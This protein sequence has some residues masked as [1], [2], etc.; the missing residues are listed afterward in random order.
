MAPTPIDPIT[1]E[2]LWSRLVAIVDEAAAAFV[3]T[4]FS[5]LVQEANDYAVVLTDSAG[6]SL[7]QSS[8]SIPSFLGT[9]PRTVRHLL[10]IFPLE[11]LRPGDVLLTNIPWMGTGHL[12]DVNMVVPVFRRGRAIAFAAVTSHMPDIGGRMWNAGNRELYEE[13]LQIPPLKLMDAGKANDTAIAFL[14]QNVRVPDQMMGDLWGQLTCCH[15]LSEGVHKMI[16]DTGVD[17]DLFGAE[18]RRRS[19]AAMRAA[20]RA[21][22]DG[23]YATRFE[24]DVGLPEPIVI[25][26]KVIVRGGALHIDYTGTTGQLPCSVNS[27]TSYTYAYSCY[28][29]KSL[30]S[31]EVPNNDGS[32]RPI[33]IFAPE[34]TVLNPRYPAACSTCGLAGHLLPPAIMRALAPALPGRVLAAP[35]SPQCSFMVT[36]EKN[37]RPFAMLNFVSGGMGAGPVQDGPSPM[38]FPSN[39]ANT[40]IELIET[41]TPLRVLERS[42]RRGTGGRGRRRGGDGQ[43]LAFTLTGPSPAVVSFLMSRRRRAAPGLLGGGPGGQGRLRINGRDVD[44]ARHWPLAPGD[45]VLI[46]TPAGGGY[47]HR[48]RARRAA[49]EP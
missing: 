8:L 3:R 46:E 42:K 10:K 41:A 20:I 23:A 29:V 14:R 34:G 15:T 1:L 27:V 6:R 11:S 16:I 22:A 49:E 21:L 26:C 5:S 36:G 45:T 12:P 25:A 13:G 33:T 40:P 44:S 43:R 35:G 39:L 19:E 18:L 30:L 4:A 9:L 2:I 48:R 7:A 31:P 28:G 32:T 38:S 37:A 17:F 47:G 24:C